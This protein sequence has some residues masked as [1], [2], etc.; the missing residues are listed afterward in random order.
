MKIRSLAA[1]VAIA[2]IM[3][4]SGLLVAKPAY[5]AAAIVIKPAGGCAFFDG[6]GGFFFTSNTQ[7][8]ATSSANGNTML[9]CSATN[10]AN[11]QGHAVTYD[12]NN[13]PFGPGVECGIGSPNGFVFTTNWHET[14]SADGNAVAVCQYKN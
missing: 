12:T 4:A 8:V 6:N 7:I 2:A 11:S 9:K 13:N 14:I 3:I 5:A 10:V 1:I